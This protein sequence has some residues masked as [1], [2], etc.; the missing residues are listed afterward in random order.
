MDEHGIVHHLLLGVIRKWCFLSLLCT[1]CKWKSILAESTMSEFTSHK[2]SLLLKAQPPR[3]TEWVYL[4]IILSLLLHAFTLGI[5]YL[6]TASPATSAEKTEQTVDELELKFEEDLREEELEA[7]SVQSERV[8]NLLANAESQRTSERV[9]YSGKSE[10]QIAKEVE[11]MYRNMEANE[12]KGLAEGRPKDQ[13]VPTYTPEPRNEATRNNKQDA[14]LSTGSNQSYSGPV[15]AEYFLK[16]RQSK[17]AP[18][19][20]YRC[21]SSGKIVVNIEVNTMG[22]VT[23][24]SI[25]EGKSSG[26]DCIREE[27]LKY[28]K[29]WTFDYNES[30]PRKQAGTIS[31]T[32]SAQ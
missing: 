13:S 23:G 8:R 3:A 32:F 30:A 14:P 20:T 12:F 2:L 17:S 28:A 15:S 4:A 25:D 7:G 26:N 9:N 22:E 19:P 29:K 10:E 18:K 1:V 27:S 21:K 16:G 6:T 31:F 24:V 5:M 11:E